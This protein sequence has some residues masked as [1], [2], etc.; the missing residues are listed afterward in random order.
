MIASLLT[1][2]ELHDQTKLEEP[3]MS[4]FSEVTPKLAGLT[5]GSDEYKAALEEIKPALDHH[6]ARNRHHP[7]H[8]KNGVNDMNLLDIVE[9]FCDWKAATLRHNDGN[10]RQSI[11][12]NAERYG[13]SEQL[14]QILINSID[15]L[16][17]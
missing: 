1:R 2:G 14:T 9:M 8:H 10:I 11:E 12:V 4:I 3:E 15:L 16:D 5:Y 17:G 7:E 13:I 6:Y